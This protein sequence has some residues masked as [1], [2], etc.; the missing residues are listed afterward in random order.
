M[1][2]DDDDA[3]VLREIQESKNCVLTPRAYARS[4]ISLRWVAGKDVRR[5]GRKLAWRDACS[6]SA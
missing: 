4:G 6:R 1:E 2:P 5:P 3:I